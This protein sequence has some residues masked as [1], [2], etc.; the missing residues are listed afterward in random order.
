MS[1]KLWKAVA[2][3]KRIYVKHRFDDM[4]DSADVLN[5]VSPRRAVL[6]PTGEAP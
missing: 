1:F 5:R 6:A 2:Q 4:N 3:G